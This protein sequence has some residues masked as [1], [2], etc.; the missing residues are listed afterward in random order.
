MSDR[1]G[2]ARCDE[3]CVWQ[4]SQFL[5]EKRARFVFFNFIRMFL[6]VACGAVMVV[7]S[8]AGGFKV[9]GLT[10]SLAILNG[11]LQAVFVCVWIMAVFRTCGFCGFNSCGI[12]ACEL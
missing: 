7:L 9:D 11:V 4:K 3:G 1:R 8:G 10:I 6:C 2:C 12:I 5:C